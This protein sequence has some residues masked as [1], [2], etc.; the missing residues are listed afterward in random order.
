LLVLLLLLLFDDDNSSILLFCSLTITVFRLSEGN[1]NSKFR[2]CGLFNFVLE[3]CSW[4]LGFDS[5]VW[6]FFCVFFYSFLRSS[7]SNSM[8]AAASDGGNHNL[9]NDNINKISN[10]SEGLSRPRRQMKTPFQLETLEKAFAC[11][12]TNLSSCFFYFFFYNYYYFAFSRF[13][14]VV[15]R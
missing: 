10:S 2:C 13:D 9:N 14:F 3:E 4:F 15:F 1:A 12:F 11:S 7:P 8:E 6:V 5:R